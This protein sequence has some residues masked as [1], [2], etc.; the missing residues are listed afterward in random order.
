MVRRPLRGNVGKSEEEEKSERALSAI[1]SHP[2]MSSIRRPAC[3]PLSAPM[4]SASLTDGE[5][6]WGKGLTVYLPIGQ[7]R[8]RLQ[9]HER[10]GQH[11]WRKMLQYILAQLFTGGRY[12]FAYDIGDQSLLP[13]F[14]LMCHYQ[15]CVYCRMLPQDCLN[16]P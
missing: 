9:D 13:R 12:L 2:L 8:Q 4:V 11:I 5:C 6:R 16:L 10:S 1:C 14:V 15:A 3:A 7:Q